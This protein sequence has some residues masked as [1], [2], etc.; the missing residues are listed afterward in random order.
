VEEGATA[1]VNLTL[2]PG[3]TL[4][5]QVVAANG[6]PLPLAAYVSAF[7]PGWGG[8]RCEAN[9]TFVL[10]H[11]APGTYRLMA[12]GSG[13]ERVVRLEKVEVQEDTPPVQIVWEEGP[14]AEG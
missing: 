10:E 13:V 11:L 9:G 5:G 2:T 7:G 3:L 8:A 6:Q 14:P 1:E 12:W 4:R